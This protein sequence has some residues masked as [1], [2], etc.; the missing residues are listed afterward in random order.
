LHTHFK[1][2]KKLSNEKF[3][4]IR[5]LDENFLPY[6]KNPRYIE[7]KNRPFSS[8]IICRFRPLSYDIPWS[9]GACVVKNML[10]GLTPTTPVTSTAIYP[11]KMSIGHK[12]PPDLRCEM[13]FLQG[14]PVFYTFLPSTCLLLTDNLPILL[15]CTPP[16][17]FSIQ[18]CRSCYATLHLNRNYSA[19]LATLQIT[20]YVHSRN[21]S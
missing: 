2:V 10:A 4:D 3:L 6:Y 14:K 15:K 13:I 21:S 7:W 12:S 11:V 9:T 20:S 5:E 19:I 16:W 1:Y 8:I 17:P 18:S